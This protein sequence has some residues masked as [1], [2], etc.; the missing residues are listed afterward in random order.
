MNR[1]E[2]LRLLATGAVLPLAPHNLLVMLRE[3]RVVVGTS[4]SPRTL[5]AHQDATVKAMAELIL[6][7]TDTP[8][9]TDVGASAFVDLI[10]T[11]WYDADDRTHFLRGLADVDS[12]PQALFGKDFVECSPLQQADILSALGEKMVE[13][14]DLVKTGPHR[15]RRSMQGQTRN[16]YSM[17]RG[18]ILTAYYT[19]EAG[20]TAELGFEVIP[21]RHQG[22]AELPSAKGSIENQ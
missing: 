17:L 11:E 7:R 13:E 3:A 16:F 15:R 8:G 12:R 20:A 2:A 14:S 1:R 6:P 5:N 19:S 10:L 9:A 21:D 22:C 18:L 4:A